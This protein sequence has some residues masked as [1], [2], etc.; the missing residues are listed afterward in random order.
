MATLGKLR[1]AGPNDPIYT[2][3][4]QVYTPLPARRPKATKKLASV[5]AEMKKDK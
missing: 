2:G 3:R 4:I 1:F 5:R